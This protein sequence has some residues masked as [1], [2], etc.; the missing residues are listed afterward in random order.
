MTVT[1]DTP[2]FTAEIRAGDSPEGPWETVSQSRTIQNRHRY[3]LENADATLGSTRVT[4]V[5]LLNRPWPN[6]TRPVT[7]LGRPRRTWLRITSAP[8]SGSDVS[9]RTSQ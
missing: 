8:R 2:G 3:T 1:T 7:A 6:A 5:A 4:A 9:A